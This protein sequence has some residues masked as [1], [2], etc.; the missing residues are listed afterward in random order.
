M[1]TGKKFYWIKIKDSFMTSD[2]VDFLMSQKNGAN[3]VVL[4]QMLCL[5][6]I[7][8]NGEM[9]RSLGEIIMPFD[10][11][12]IQRDCKYFEI[13]TIRVALE[14]YKKLGMVYTND[15]G[16]LQITDFSNMVGSETD[17]AEQKRNQKKL[18]DNNEQM[19]CI[20]ISSEMIGLPNGKAQFVDE[21]RYGGNGMNAFELAQGRCEMCS[22]ENNLLIHHNNGYSNEQEDLFVLCKSCH[23]I[24]HST[25]KPDLKHNWYG[26]DVD[27]GVEKFHI[28]NRDKILDIRDKEIDK[29]K[30]NTV[31]D[32][33]QKKLKFGTYKNVLL[34][35]DEYERLKNDYYSL[36]MNSVIEWFSAYIEEKAYKSKSHNLAI[37]RWVIDAYSNKNKSNQ[38]KSILERI[39]NL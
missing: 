37:R 22:S 32:T 34:T 4:Y 18:K 35:E 16:I 23:G 2:K 24:V 10:E 39:E 20:R 1:A 25:Y 36:D 8:T 21:K 6:T 11:T 9:S 13:D 17:Y 33:K 31:S 3:Y 7:N 15:N 29:E 30:D 19:K 38:Q 27:S 12:K 5:K 14:L 26:Q 28:E